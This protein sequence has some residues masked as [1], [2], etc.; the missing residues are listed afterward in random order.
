MESKLDIIEEIEF[1]RRN[2]KNFSNMDEYYNKI[3]KLYDKLSL[4]IQKIDEQIEN[5]DKQKEKNNNNLNNK[6]ENNGKQLD[7]D[8]CINSDDLYDILKNYSDS[9]DDFLKI[10]NIEKLSNIFHLFDLYLIENN[11]KEDTNKIY[12]VQTSPILGNYNKLIIISKIKLLLHLCEI[13]IGY[14]NKSIIT[15]IIFN[16]LMSNYQFVLDHPKFQD[17]VKAKLIYL[18]ENDINKIN[19]IINRYNLDNN[20]LT[21]WKQNFNCN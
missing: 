11:K 5:I 12:N 19:E 8:N 16:E 14:K 18:V 4:R 13:S 6:N 9:M 20:L 15:L 10:K 17:T 3:T 7:I 21:K 1:L 2:K